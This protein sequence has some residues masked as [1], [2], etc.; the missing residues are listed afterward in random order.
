MKPKL[1]SAPYENEDA[2]SVCPYGSAA[3]RARWRKQHFNPFV[4]ADG[5]QRKM[6][7]ATQS[8]LL[9]HPLRGHLCRS[10]AGFAQLAQELTALLDSARMWAA[11]TAIS[12]P[13]R[14]PHCARG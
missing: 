14:R 2:K 12:I 4:V 11:R 1:P 10:A 8:A 7:F 13:R 9:R 6:T 5:H 3:S